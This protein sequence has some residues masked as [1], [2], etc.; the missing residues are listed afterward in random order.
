MPSSRP[1][2]FLL[3]AILRSLRFFYLLWGG[4]L[5]ATLAY[6]SRLRFPDLVWHWPAAGRVLSGPW[7]RGLAL[8]AGLTM[9]L[10]A[11]FEIWELVDLLLSH[12]MPDH[13]R[14]HRR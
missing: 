11:L 1:R 14:D 4:L 6:Y 8:G 12:F 10:A 7:G 9:L 13:D 3:D 5:L 2:P